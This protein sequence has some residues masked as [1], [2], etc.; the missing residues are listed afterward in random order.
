MWLTESLLALSSF[1]LTQKLSRR[2]S[3][4]TATP[5]PKFDRASPV[6]S[7]GGWAALPDGATSIAH[8]ILA[9]LHLMGFDIQNR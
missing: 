7:S 3:P 2:E 9:R 4:V 5:P 8:I 1:H 6:G